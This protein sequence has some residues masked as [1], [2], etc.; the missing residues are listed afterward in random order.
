[1]SD[2]VVW[3]SGATDGIGLGLARTVPY[4]N[5][6]VINLSRRQHPDFETVQFDLTQPETYAAVQQ[7]SFYVRGNYRF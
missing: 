1:M 7:R 4:P 6:R 5:A 2:T 3:I